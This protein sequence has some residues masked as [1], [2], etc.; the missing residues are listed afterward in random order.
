MLSAEERREITLLLRNCAAALLDVAPGDVR[1]GRVA[2]LWRE[3]VE[4]SD[5]VLSSGYGVV[6]LYI[7][8]GRFKAA[9]EGYDRPHYRPG[10]EED[11]EEGG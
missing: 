10:R 6:K 11:T 3:T 8:A 4:S 5:R 7:Q 2:E 1:A 9:S